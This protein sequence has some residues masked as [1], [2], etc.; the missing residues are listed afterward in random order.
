MAFALT[1]P[2]AHPGMSG[3]RRQVPARCLF[4]QH[5]V[6]TG[7]FP[8][9]DSRLLARLQKFREEADCG[10]SFPVDDAGAREELAAARAFVNQVAGSIEHHRV[11]ELDLDAR[12][13]DGT[14]ELA[15]GSWGWRPLHSTGR[16]IFRS[17]AF[18]RG[19]EWRGVSQK[20]IF[21]QRRLG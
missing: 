20:S 21:T 5:L 7:R 10:E 18:Q 8:V 6:K 11:V 12:G 16:F 3:R 4:N 9:A 14:P 17:S 15:R 1:G 2:S 13:E 19:S